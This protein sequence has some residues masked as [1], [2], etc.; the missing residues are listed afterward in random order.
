MKKILNQYYNTRL[1]KFIL[2]GFIYVIFWK[3]AGFELT[4]IIIGSTILAELDFQ[5]KNK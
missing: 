1:G 2:Y 5:Y 3:I 4:M